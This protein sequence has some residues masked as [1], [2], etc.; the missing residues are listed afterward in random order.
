MLNGREVKPRCMCHIRSGRPIRN[1]INEKAPYQR[2]WPVVF[3]ARPLWAACPSSLGATNAAEPLAIRFDSIS[4]RSGLI[5]SI[6]TTGD[7]DGR[8][9]FSNKDGGRR[10]RPAVRSRRAH[11]CWRPIASGNPRRVR[12]GSRAQNRGTADGHFAC[13]P[14][15]RRRSIQGPPNSSVLLIHQGL[16]HLLGGTSLLLPIGREGSDPVRLDIDATAV[17]DDGKFVSVRPGSPA[18]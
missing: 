6:I 10:E 11:P 5:L 16:F 8:T 9:T 15:D 3:D 18:P 7:T 13:R 14:A 17:A 12:L 2:E 1:G 4:T